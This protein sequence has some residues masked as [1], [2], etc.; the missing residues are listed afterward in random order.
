MMA[1]LQN[2]SGIW[3]SLTWLNLIQLVLDFESIFATVP[4]GSKNYVCFKSGQ[5]DLKI[6]IS[7]L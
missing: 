7:L 2:V 1:F 3:T 5:S 4:A 6:I